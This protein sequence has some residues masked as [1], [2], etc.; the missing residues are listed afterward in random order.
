MSEILAC[1]ETNSHWAIKVDSW[2]S[3]VHMKME[4]DPDL[5]TLWVFKT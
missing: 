1:P 2:L 4:A 3:P 5:E